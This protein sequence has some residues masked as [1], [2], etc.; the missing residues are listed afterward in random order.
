MQDK[1]G[2]SHFTALGGCSAGGVSTLEAG[3][4]EPCTAQLQHQGNAGAAFGMISVA[5]RGE[6]RGLRRA[7]HSHP[8]R[9]S[10]DWEEIA[11]T[12]K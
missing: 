8:H 11:G 1:R 5:T 2:N 4:A 6:V 9:S 3:N 7:P 10:G 12:P